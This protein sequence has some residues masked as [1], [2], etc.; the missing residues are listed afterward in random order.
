LA[1]KYRNT[2]YSISV[3]ASTDYAETELIVN[4][5]ESCIPMP[6]II[7]GGLESLHNEKGY[8]DSVTS[9]NLS[10]YFDGFVYD[11]STYVKTLSPI[12]ILKV[13]DSQDNE[14]D[15]GRV[16]IDNGTL[17]IH[18]LYT[19]MELKINVTAE[20]TT[21][22]GVKQSV[23][24]IL[25]FHE[26]IAD[27]TVKKEIGQTELLTNVAIIYDLS[28]NF[29]KFDGEELIYTIEDSTMEWCTIAGNILTIEPNFRDRTYDVTVV[30]TRTRFDGL[31]KTAKTKLSISEDLQAVKFVSG[32]SM[33]HNYITSGDHLL[34][35]KTFQTA[36]SPFLS[37]DNISYSIGVYKDAGL[38][39]IDTNH[40]VILSNSTLYL[41]GDMRNKFYY[42]KVMCSNTNHL[43]NTYN[44]FFTLKVKENIGPVTLLSPSDVGIIELTNARVEF[45]LSD[46]FE[47]QDIDYS[48]E[49]LDSTGVYVDVSITN[50][51][52]RVT[53]DYRDVS[54]S[55][56][57]TAGNTDFTGLSYNEAVSKLFHITEMLKPENYTR[58][59]VESKPI[60]NIVL[61]EN[62]STIDLA[63][64]YY[65]YTSVLIGDFDSSQ[66]DLT[67]INDSGLVS[68]RVT[69]T[70]G[71]LTFLGDYRDKT[72]YIVVRLKNGDGDV[73]DTQFS[74]SE[75]IATPSI[76]LN[77]SMLNAPMLN[78][79]P[80]TISLVPTHFDGDSLAFKIDVYTITD[81]DMLGIE[82]NMATILN[83]LLTISPNFRNMNYY[84]RV[85][86][87]NV[88]HMGVSHES[89]PSILT[90]IENTPFPISAIQVENRTLISQPFEYNLSE[91]F[92]IAPSDF[93]YKILEVESMSDVNVIISHAV[94][95]IWKMFVYPNYL[96]EEYI[97]QVIASYTNINNLDNDISVNITISETIAPPYVWKELSLFTCVVFDGQ[98]RVYYLEDFFRGPELFLEMDVIEYVDGVAQ[99]IANDN[100]VLVDNR[101]EI[102]GSA[103]GKEYSVVVR[104][105]NANYLGEFN[106][107]VESTLTVFETSNANLQEGVV[108]EVGVE[109]VIGIL[110]GGLEKETI[111]VMSNENKTYKLSN[112]FTGSQRTY[113][114]KIKAVNGDELPVELFDVSVYRDK[115][116][117]IL[118]LI[119]ANHRDMYY[120][121]EVTAISTTNTSVRCV[122][123]LYVVETVERPFITSN[124]LE[125]RS[126]LFLSNNQRTFILRLYFSGNFHFTSESLQVF[127]SEHV[128][129]PPSEHG[130][131]LNT[132]E[133][134]L[135]VQ[136]NYRNKSYY[137]QI[138]VETSNFDNVYKF[139][140]QPSILHVVE[141]IEPIKFS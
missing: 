17:V 24:S 74:V 108:G 56:K 105:N 31:V 68:T 6:R 27:L 2:A 94:D 37:G 25:I 5:S 138:I 76:T 35:D 139:L 9:V 130:A 45:M 3:I 65:N 112:Y 4:V 89:P 87:S 127:S 121:V 12:Y 19:N 119:V 7:N 83:G 86:A 14:L 52:L 60:P 122:S 78:G 99:I 126:I 53:P 90:I 88:D 140:S 63:D 125:S 29:N 98:K 97:I 26:G 73:Y 33:L 96:N 57:V 109:P 20:N 43:G 100:V 131:S 102:T 107:P 123:T 62:T 84:V 106:D 11:Y 132:Q 75:T 113:E 46:Y 16:V 79:E 13:Y 129:L 32:T 117:D 71:I 128:L 41:Y 69:N 110:N 42:V 81:G 135:T 64:H 21:F 8:N 50:K 133:G 58:V 34:L 104:A 48:Y 23:V 111:V 137:V 28:E 40:N 38:T 103:L 70:S 1:A 47:G 59:I 18:N 10:T 51:V 115:N 134:T 55:I 82:N 118:L 85:V 141:N 36:L 77:L 39:I 61:V 92:A 120:N 116:Q 67:A 72:Y 91:M 114:Y 124:G 44:T 95:G 15:D 30:A 80:Y 54:Y 93:S 136:G 66:P 101:L 49:V 22:A